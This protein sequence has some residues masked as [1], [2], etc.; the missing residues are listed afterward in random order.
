MESVDHVLFWSLNKTRLVET[1]LVS[2]Q[3]FNYTPGYGQGKWP[4]KS[5]VL[6]LHFHGTKE[7]S[8]KMTTRV[9]VSLDKNAD[10]E[11]VQ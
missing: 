9:N 4:Q 6:S 7:W 11:N 1:Q 2:K 3:D 10:K 5:Q 8:T